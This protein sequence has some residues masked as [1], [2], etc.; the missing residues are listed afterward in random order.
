[1]EIFLGVLVAFLVVRLVLFGVVFLAITFAAFLGE[2]LSNNH[3]D[4]EEL[5]ALLESERKIRK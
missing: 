1:M 5:D 4:F 2:P 3:E